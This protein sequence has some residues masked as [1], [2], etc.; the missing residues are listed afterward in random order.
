MGSSEL[1]PVST[2]S[3]GFLMIKVGGHL[4]RKHSQILRSSKASSASEKGLSSS[5]V[6]GQVAGWLA[7][8]VVFS[9]FKAM[10][11]KGLHK[12]ACCASVL[13]SESFHPYFYY[14]H[15]GVIQILWPAASPAMGGP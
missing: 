1:V 12:D 2:E 8:P 15:L 3:S 9:A 5:S 13:C 11:A 4:S 14:P 10:L 7:P 6:K